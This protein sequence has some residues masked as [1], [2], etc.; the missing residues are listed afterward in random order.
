MYN[1]ILLTVLMSHVSFSPK[2]YRL[3]NSIKHNSKTGFC[4]KKL[5]IGK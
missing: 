4:Q 5:R 1:V 3:N 2:L